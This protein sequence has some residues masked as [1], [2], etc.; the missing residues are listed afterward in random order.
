MRTLPL[1]DTHQVSTQLQVIIITMERKESVS[2]RDADILSQD[3]FLI[4]SG[5]RF[6]RSPCAHSAHATSVAVGVVQRLTE[7][8]IVQDN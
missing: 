8:N 7:R 6:S 5:H 4:R 2:S 1:Q 3:R